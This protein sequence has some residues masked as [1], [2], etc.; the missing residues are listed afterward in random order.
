MTS[1]PLSLR[2]RLISLTLL[3]V[4]AVWAVT[5]V[6]TYREARHEVDE[7]LDAHLA[8]AAAILVA[9]SL[10]ELHENEVLQTPLLHH[11]ARKVAFQAY[12]T[13]G[14]LRLASANAPKTPLGNNQPGF[15]EREIEGRRWRVFSAPT[16]NGAL[17]I[18]VG[19]IDA[20]RED[21]A[22]ELIMHFLQPL[23]FALPLLALLLAFAVRRALLPLVEVTRELEIRAA[24]NLA[25]LPL[26]TT[27]AEIVPLVARMNTLFAGIHRALE[28]ERRFTAD[29]AHE[30]RTPLAALKAQAQ[31]AHAARNQRERDHALEQVTSGCDRAT[32]LV[33]QML[34]LARLDAQ[35][36]ATL[37][38][39]DLGALLEEVL[40][41][42]AGE[43][44]A[45][46]CELALTAEAADI[47]GNAVLLRVLVRNLVA[48][49]L[50]HGAPSRIEV[51]LRKGGTIRLTVVDDGPGVPAAEY[52]ML[53][54]RFRRLASADFSSTPAT[55]P[56]GSGLG[57]SIV[58]R[59]AELHGARIEFGAGPGGRGLA[60]S[61]DFPRAGPAP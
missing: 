31:V 48:N 23:L 41:E 1:R 28:N 7:L 53:G 3:A 52:D 44:I 39:L 32:H 12:T 15:A 56:A 18:H 29:A 50:G 4:G 11:Y 34:L 25:P 38:P 14:E 16:L 9:Q 55:T 54:Q 59:I 24:D 19:E 51:T 36:T 30:L 43:A 57:L 27:P 6:F 33:E 49:A 60:V 17:M 8:Q 5:A 13:A 42:M 58:R 45:H 26:T 47:A 22:H 37:A 20:A 10:H 21:V 35:T 61:V 46:D 2:L 40:A